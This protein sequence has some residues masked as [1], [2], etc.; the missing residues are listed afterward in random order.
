MTDAGDT[1][2]IVRSRSCLRAGRRFVAVAWLT[3]LAAG[4]WLL[5][6]VQFGLEGVDY[7]PYIVL[8]ALVGVALGIAG[9]ALAI[10][11]LRHHEL[12]NWPNVLLAAAGLLP[13]CVILGILW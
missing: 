1:G 13:C 10:T 5:W 11:A 2:T 3:A 12:R 9:S 7:I 4:L 6:S 8:L